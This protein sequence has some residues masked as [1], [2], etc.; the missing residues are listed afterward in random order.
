MAPVRLEPEA[1]RYRIKHSTTEPLRS[2]GYDEFCE[3]SLERLNELDSFLYAA[4]L[5]SVLIEYQY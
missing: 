3:L 5:I 4:L 1:S 2:L